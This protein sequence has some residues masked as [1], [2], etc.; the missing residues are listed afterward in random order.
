[1]SGLK[2][3]VLFAGAA[4]EERAEGNKIRKRKKSIW[5][6]ECKP[7]QALQKQ[8]Q[9]ENIR[10]DLGY[11]DNMG[12]AKPADLCWLCEYTGPLQVFAER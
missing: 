2:H 8:A 7:Q 10:N 12:L 6:S 4:R 9:R 3:N 5:N 11:W 1:M